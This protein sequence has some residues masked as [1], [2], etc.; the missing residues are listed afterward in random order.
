MEFVGVGGG[1]RFPPPF[2]DAGHLVPM[3]DLA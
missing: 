3:P 2:P 1:G